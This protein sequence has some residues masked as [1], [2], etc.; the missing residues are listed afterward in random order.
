MNRTAFTMIG[1]F[2]LLCA[3]VHAQV[4]QLIN[5]QGRVVVGTTNFSGTGQFKFALING[6]NSS[7]TAQAAVSGISGG[8]IQSVVVNVTGNGY[9]SAPAVT[10]NDP[11]S[12]GSGATATATISF[13]HVSGIT[14]TNGGA[15]YGPSTS[16]TIANPPS[17]LNFTYWSNDGTSANG[18]QPTNPVSITVSNGLYSVLLG[19]TSLPSMTAVPE[20]IAYYSNAD[21]R[22][23]V[24]FNDGSHGWQLLSPDQRIASV[25]Y[26]FGAG[27]V[28]DTS[29]GAVAFPSGN[30]LKIQA[31]GGIKLQTGGS[32]TGVTLTTSTDSANTNGLNINGDITSTSV[33]TAAVGTFSGNVSANSFTT[34]SDRNAKERFRPIDSRA[35]LSHLVSLPIETWTFK[36]DNTGV[37]HI[38]PMAQDFYAA[39]KV[40]MDDRHIATVDEEG[41]ALAAIQGLNEIVQEQNAELAVKAKEIDALEKRLDEI[42]KTLK[43]KTTTKTR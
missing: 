21:V 28:G 39:F 7:A 41:V 14:V 16:V 11:T 20:T 37:Q 13:G 43:H 9:T 31:P 6:T 4:P 35:I 5:Y 25:I 1:V 29:T 36:Q 42:E 10:F 33:L 15:N 32:G 38:G 24:W 22:L 18:S 34:T 2:V 30:Q 23:R 17:N 19:D 12:Q 3:T 8:T 40:G 27:A 26:A